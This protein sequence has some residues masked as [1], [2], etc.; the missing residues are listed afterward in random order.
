MTQVSMGRRSRSP[1]SLVLAHDIAG[2]LNNA[3]ELLCCRR[4]RH[5]A[6][7]SRFRSCH[8]DVL[9]SRCGD[10]VRLPLRV[11]LVNP[12]TFHDVRPLSLRPRTTAEAALGLL[13][14]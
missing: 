6:E 9:P 4:S 11:G 10:F 13:N 1:L 5:Q 2:R 7:L 3:T 12:C 14:G 8:L